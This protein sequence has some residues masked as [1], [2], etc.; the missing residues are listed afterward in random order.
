MYI[1][2][3]VA[4]WQDGLTVEIMLATAELA[5]IPSASGFLALADVHTIAT[6]QRCILSWAWQHVISSYRL[7]KKSLSSLL[8]GSGLLCVNDES[9]VI[10]VNSLDCKGTLII[11]I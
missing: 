9:V 6:Y 3:S 4:Y 2:S 1:N 7:D 10:L 11:I 5:D 8:K